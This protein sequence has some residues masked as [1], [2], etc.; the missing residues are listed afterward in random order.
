MEHF[1]LMPLI[2][3]LITAGI[4]TMA[5]AA[6]PRDPIYR[7]CAAWG[8]TT[9]I[10]NLGVFG[11]CV[12]ETKEAARILAHLTWMGVVFL[13]VTNLH[14][15]RLSFGLPTPSFKWLYV[16]TAMVAALT[17]TPW[18]ITGAR[19]VAEAWYAVPGPLLWIFVFGCFPVIGFF[20]LRPLIPLACARGNPQQPRALIASAVL[21]LMYVGGGNDYLGV[22]GFDHY[23]FTDVPIRPWGSLA[24]AAYAVVVGYGVFSDQLVEMRISLGRSAAAALRLVFLLSVFAILLAALSLAWPSLLGIRGYAAAVAILVISALITLKVSP[25]LLHTPSESLKVLVEGDRFDYLEKIAALREG[26]REPTELQSTLEKVC[27][28]LRQSLRLGDV[29]I[30]Y[31]DSVG[32]VRVIASPIERSPS[33]PDSLFRGWSEEASNDLLSTGYG[34]RIKL[35]ASSERAIG[36]LSL[37]SAAGRR[38]KLNSHDTRALTEL[39]QALRHRLE[40]EQIHESESLRRANAAKDRFLA[41]INHEIRNPLNGLAGLLRMLREEHLGARPAHL[42]SVMSACT[43]QLCATMDNVLDF[44]QLSGAEPTLRNTTFELDAL[45]QSIANQ[46]TLDASARVHIRNSVGPLRLESDVGKLRQILGNLVGNALKYGSPPHAELA[47]DRCGSANADI[48]LRFSVINPSSDLAQE[49]L[50]ELFQPFKRGL[51]AQQTGAPGSGLGLSICR[52]LVNTLGGTSGAR[53]E[54]NCA[55]FWFE[56]D[57]AASTSADPSLG[58]LAASEEATAH[59]SVH[60]LQVL[61]IEDE[62]YNRLVLAHE[63]NPWPVSITWAATGSEAELRILVRAAG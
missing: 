36:F 46:H 61:A 6:S 1:F 16:A 63:L 49:N 47:V 55:V 57:F 39:A 2:A 38:L 31:L 32:A 51:R 48:R 28:G 13:P 56:T 25:K 45:L 42:L 10:W 20:T 4:A 54:N 34:W 14:F 35:G 52:R 18:W 11:L 33:D 22:L 62:A 5:L 21:L 43:E 50:E 3:G 53:H 23:P 24:A 29:L 30:V 15:V 19:Q 12:V 60:K 27:V 26:L 37:R 40:S 9:A 44:A 8:V 17:L 7:A 59:H 41:G 58:S